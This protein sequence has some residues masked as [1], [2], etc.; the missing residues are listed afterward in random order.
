ML[1]EYQRSTLAAVGVTSIYW[2]FDPLM[3]KNAYFNINRLGATI[4]EY[5]PDMY[6]M[7]ASPLHLGM[8][9]DRLI[10]RLDTSAPGGSPVMLSVDAGLPIL[11][12]APGRED[13]LL[14][15]G[16]LTP[17]TVLLEMPTEILDV[18]E[19]S[20]AAA[21]MWRFAVRDNFRWAL[22]RGYSVAGVYRNPNVDRAFYVLARGTATTD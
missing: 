6:G 10:V 8:P 18:L 16:E 7:T 4:V 20:P 19:R 21:Q 12:P 14:M 13:N 9:T 2:S 11:T 15:I 3:A 1:K 17:P 22:R 5:V